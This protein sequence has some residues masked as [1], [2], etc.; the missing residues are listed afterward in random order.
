M[1]DRGEEVIAVKLAINSLEYA[2]L[3]HSKYLDHFLPFV[4]SFWYNE[5]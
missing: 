1:I 3:N 2:C 5:K 4:L